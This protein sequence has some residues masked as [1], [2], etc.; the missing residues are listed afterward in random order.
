MCLRR[1]PEDRTLLL[2]RGGAAPVLQERPVDKAERHRELLRAARDVFATKGYHDAKV[3]DIVA[4]AKVAKGTFY[5]YFSD[6][7]S[8]F[9][10]LVDLLFA[11]MGAAIVRVDPGS[12]VEGQVK[13][14]IRAIVAVLLDDPPLSQILLSYAPGLDPAF[15]AKIRSFYDGVKTLL[16]AAL[17]EGQKLG[18]VADGDTKLYA[19]FTLGALKEVVLETSTL[20]EAR[21]REEIVSGLFELLQAG[22]LRIAPPAPRAA[23]LS[24]RAKPW[25]AKSSREKSP[26]GKRS[27]SSRTPTRARPR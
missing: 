26:A 9:A 16:Q 12:D 23:V 5:L 21:P 13:H 8:V 15:V 2:R 11:R 22:Y 20:V 19:T 25:K 7:R 18:I 27:P 17:E 4:A 24:S 10:E 14:N 6:K 1:V 3:D